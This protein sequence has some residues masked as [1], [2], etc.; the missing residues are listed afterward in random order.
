MVAGWMFLFN[1]GHWEITTLTLSSGKTIWCIITKHKLNFA[2]CMFYS[3]LL[4][5]QYIFLN[6]YVHLHL[7]D[8]FSTSNV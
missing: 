7:A 5:Y 3:K 8:H 2:L 6:I 1:P 4:Y